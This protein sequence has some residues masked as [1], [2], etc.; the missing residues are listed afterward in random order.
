[1]LSQVRS[2]ALEFFSVSG[3]AGLSTLIPAGAMY[4]IGFAWP[5]Y[6]TV[7]RAMDGE[8]GALLR[9]QINAAGI[10]VM[11]RIWN[12]GFRQMTTRSTPITRPEDLAGLKMRVPVSTLWT[13]MFS[14]LGAFPTS[15]NLSEVYSALQTKVVDGQE[16]PLVTISTTKFYEVQ[17]YCSLTNPMGAGYGFLGTRRAW[18]RLPAGIKEVVSRHINDAAL[19]QRADV[20]GLGNSLRTELQGQG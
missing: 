5:D 4:G 15:I 9:K 11:D 13:S 16:N 10:F 7:W 18:E 20:E 3:V 2:G 8:L 19:R 14:A 6:P 1:M 17:K 12:S